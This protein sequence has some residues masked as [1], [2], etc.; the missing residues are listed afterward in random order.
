VTLQEVNRTWIEKLDLIGSAYP[1]RVVCPAPFFSSAILSRR[2][3]V[4]GTTPSCD[5]GGALAVAAVDFGGQSV[6]VVSVHL[7]WPWP[8]GQARQIGR[9]APRLG[10]VGATA[11]LGGDF[12][13]SPWSIAVRRVAA[14]AGMTRMERLGPTWMDRRAPTILRPLGLPIDQMMSKGGIVVK[15]AH[16]LEPVGSDHLPVLMEFSIEPA[17]AEPAVQTVR[18]NQTPREM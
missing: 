5:V 7:K 14:F 16:T 12:N 1:Y 18:A 2:P 10:Q 6:D 15:S 9:M 13:A 11:L 17:P 8:I 3:F 4:D